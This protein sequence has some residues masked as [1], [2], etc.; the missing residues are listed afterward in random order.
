MQIASDLAT[1]IQGTDTALLTKTLPEPSD[2]PQ[3]QREALRGR[4]LELAAQLDGK[5][6]KTIRAKLIKAVDNMPDM[7]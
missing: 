2:T 6:W 7:A 4:I 3:A 1:R 5:N